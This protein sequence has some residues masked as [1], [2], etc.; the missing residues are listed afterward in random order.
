MPSVAFS[1]IV[2]LDLH[3]SSAFGAIVLVICW[4]FSSLKSSMVSNLFMIPTGSNET[5]GTTKNS[6]KLSNAG[7]GSLSGL[8]LST[9]TFTNFFFDSVT[10]DSISNVYLAIEEL[11]LILSSIGIIIMRIITTT[12]PIISKGV[13]PRN[14]I[15]HLLHLFLLFVI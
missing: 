14:I 6:M 8:P 12:I 7:E 15:F 13:I 1:S 2:I 3:S 10:M 9:Q 4:N 11:I 5:G